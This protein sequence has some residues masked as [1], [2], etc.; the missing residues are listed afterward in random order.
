MLGWWLSL[1][2]ILGLGL[3]FRIRVKVRVR[4]RIGVRFRVRF[5]IRNSVRI[6]VMVRIGM[7]R[8]GLGLH[9]GLRLGMGEFHLFVGLVFFVFWERTLEEKYY[10]FLELVKKR[11]RP[12]KHRKLE[13]LSVTHKNQWKMMQEKTKQ[14]PSKEPVPHMT[15]IVITQVCL[16]FYSLLV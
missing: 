8:L 11:E 15:L 4:F 1:G 7:L 5:K 10:M 12:G 14:M 16:L 13:D 3:S 6:R 2:L 9:L